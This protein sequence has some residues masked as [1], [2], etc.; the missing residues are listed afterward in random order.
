MLD[1]S[2][3]PGHNQCKYKHNCCFIEV[4]HYHKK[5]CIFAIHVLQVYDNFSSHG[6]HYGLTCL[7]S[8]LF[9]TSDISNCWLWSL[10]LWYEEVLWYIHV[11]RCPFVMCCWTGMHKRTWTEY[12]SC[13]CCTAERRQDVWHLPRSRVGETVDCRSTIRNS[14]R[15]F[16]HLLPCLH[17][18]MALCRPVWQR[19]HQVRCW[20]NSFYGAII[21]LHTKGFI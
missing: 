8:R 3:W 2:W 18:A 14:F 17:P 13:V 21:V 20:F 4:A 19:G 7:I 11:H 5:N 6:V 10:E 16:S 15:L 12:G 9:L 1:S